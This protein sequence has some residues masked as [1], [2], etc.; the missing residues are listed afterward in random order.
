[1]NEA[2]RNEFRRHLKDKNINE[3]KVRALLLTCMDYRYPQAI[4]TYMDCQG[5]NLDYDHV[6]LAGASLGAVLDEEPHLKPHWHDTFFDHIDV[7]IDLHSIEVVYILDHRDCGAYRVFRGLP[8][9]VPRDI[10][11]RA[12]QK[13]MDKLRAAILAEHSGLTVK[14]GLLE[15]IDGEEFRVLELE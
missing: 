12:H 8:R 14:C 3:E 11:T 7:A 13:E 15:K 5:Y 9:D 2:E 4:V 10:E 6:I 1:M